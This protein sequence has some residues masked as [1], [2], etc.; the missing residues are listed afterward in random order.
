MIIWK[1]TNYDNNLGNSPIWFLFVLHLASEH[2]QD[3]TRVHGET[4]SYSH[5]QGTETRVDI[6]RERALASHWQNTGATGK[7]TVGTL[8]PL[9]VA[10]RPLVNGR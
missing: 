1:L 6:Y 5:W 4:R 7:P 9:A 3:P 2:P 8:V 10:E